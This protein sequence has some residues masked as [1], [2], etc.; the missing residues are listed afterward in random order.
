MHTFDTEDMSITFLKMA[1]ND[2]RSKQTNR[3]I[4]GNNNSS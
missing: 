3:L 1:A 2:G 4:F